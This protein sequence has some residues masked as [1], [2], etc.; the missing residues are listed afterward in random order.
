MHMFGCYI[1]CYTTTSDE[2]F[3]SFKKYTKTFRLFRDWVFFRCH[4]SHLNTFVFCECEYQHS[5]IISDKI[6]CCQS[7]ARIYG[8]M[9]LRKW[10][11]V[12]VLSEIDQIGHAIF[13]FGILDPHCFSLWFPDEKNVQ[14]AIKN[15][16]THSRTNEKSK[17][18]IHRTPIEFIHE[19]SSHVCFF[20]L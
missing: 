17:E 11:R 2:R 19:R 14:A 10:S 12:S 8:T 16:H 4:S 6:L 13:E 9:V 5:F 1:T 18:L 15:M 7:A 20:S 3:H